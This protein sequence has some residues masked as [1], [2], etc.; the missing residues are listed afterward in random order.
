MEE[1]LKSNQMKVIRS[2]FNKRECKM[3]KKTLILIASFC[4]IGLTIGI[5]GWYWLGP[6]KGVNFDSISLKSENYCIH[7]FANYTVNGYARQKTQINSGIYCEVAQ[8]TFIVYSSGKNGAYSACAPY[9]ISYDHVQNTWS[10]EVKIIDSPVEPD[11]HNYPQIIVDNDGFLH[12]FHSFHN[13]HPVA[14]AISTSPYDISNWT[15]TYLPNST[16]VTYGAAFKAING[17]IYYMARNRLNFTPDYEPEYYWKSTD[18]GKTF[19]ISM[20]INPYPYDDEWGTI[21]TKAVKYSNAPE[22]LL[23]T[24]GVH[25]YHNHYFDD[26][27]YVLFDFNSNELFSASGVNLGTSMNRS[28][29]EEHCRIFEYGYDVPFFN[30]RM[31]VNLDQ[32][33]HPVVFYNYMIEEGKN[34]LTRAKW[35]NV[36]Q[37][38]IITDYNDLQEIYPQELKVNGTNGLELY[39]ISGK[40]ELC[41][42]YFSESNYTG[43]SSI[44]LLEKPQ[45]MSFANL[46]FIDNAHPDIEGTFI[47]RK[48]SVWSKPRRWGQYCTFGVLT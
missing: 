25:R 44:V 20:L 26:H 43:K 45:D 10:S 46:N 8:K 36:S 27:Y 42:L 35:D 12:V 16:M 48:Y 18:N 33:G 2:K 1:N 23:I 34:I 38:W 31:V 7:K 14:H 37:N 6:Q 19:N 15:I 32:D 17:D 5:G 4:I 11:A 40:K 22:G 39:A 41:I 3:K 9:I 47:G 30:T 24:F 21:Y 13:N 29:F 28:V